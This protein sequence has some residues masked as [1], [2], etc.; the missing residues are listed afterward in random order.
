MA[1]LEKYKIERLVLVPTLLRS[2]LWYLSL[3]GE[4]SRLKSLKYWVCS[5]EEL[6]ISLAREFFEYFEEHEQ[7]LFNFYG[8]TEV[9]GDV[10][11]FE[12]ESKKQLSSL[13]KIPIGSPINNTMVYILDKNNEPVKEGA[14]GELY[15][16]GFNLA[17]GYV[18]GRDPEKFIENPLS[19][20]PKYSRLYRTGDFASIK[21]GLIFYEGRTDSQIKIRGHRVDLSEVEKQV[22]SVSGI[23]KATVLC[24]NVG[25]L[26]QTLLAFVICK[27]ENLLTAEEIERELKQVMVSYMIPKVVI[28]ETLPLL[29]NGKIDR[30]ALLKMFKEN[31]QNCATELIESYNFDVVPAH[32]L[33]AAKDL[34]HTVANVL[35][36][37]TKSGLCL[38]RSFYEY[39]GNSLNSIYTVT[40]LQKKG[41]HI[42]IT[43]FINAKTL[44][45]VLDKLEPFTKNQNLNDEVKCNLKLKAVPL[46]NQHK[47]DVIE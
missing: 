24:Q 9:M 5:G 8:S 31:E 42:T 35:K 1:I 38:Q 43:D 15:V 26:D 28:I 45:E 25:E 7:K 20:D 2:I 27:S 17:I 3:N 29:V 4:K 16:S 33:E 13:E 22:S 12:C 37:T 21:K 6:S 14:V 40:E 30:Q 36:T 34:L 10:T 44:L 23:E 47:K 39:G 32:K 19:A 46:E 11:F 18:N 41:Y